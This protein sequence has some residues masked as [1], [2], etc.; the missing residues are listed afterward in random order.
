MSEPIRP[1]GKIEVAPA[2]IASVISEAV[3]TCYGVV[4]T[5]PKNFATG[6]VD[7]LSADRKRGVE[8]QFRDG[9]ITV[10]L[11]VVVEYGTR[12]SIVAESIKHVVK[13]QVEKILE[14]PVAKVNVHI[15]ALRVSDTD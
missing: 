6:L 8:V 7:I 14:L 1:R 12:V 10:D 15:Q 3:Q 4:G 2:A 9:K 5:V 13:Y 11:Y